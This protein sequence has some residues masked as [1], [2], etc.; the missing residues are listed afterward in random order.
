[1]KLKQLQEAK[2]HREPVR[3][4]DAIE[5]YFEFLVNGLGHD[6]EDAEQI[7]RDAAE[8]TLDSLVDRGL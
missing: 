5:A 1:M 6:E 2:Y 7:C 3:I 4:S 8:E